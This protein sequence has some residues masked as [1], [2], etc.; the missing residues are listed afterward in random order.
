M[1]LSID[2]K[3]LDLLLEKKRDYIGRKTSIVGLVEAILLVISAYTESYDN[4]LIP[5]LAIKFGILVLAVIQV[6][7]FVSELRKPKYSKE[8]LLR[9]IENLDMARRSSS[10]IAI[11]NSK[12]HLQYLLYKDAGWGFPLFPNYA[13]VSENETNIIR[14]LSDQLDINP[15]QIRLEFKTEGHEIKYS[16]ESKEEREYYYRFYEA[17]IDSFK[18]ED[19]E[20]FQSEG[21]TFIWM[22]IDEMLQDPVINK[23][24]HYVVGMVRDNT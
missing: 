23:N 15:D 6:I 20:E 21:R 9:D 24:N 16:T 5:S 10:I 7:F 2:P 19:E 14:K 4:F 13:T 3:E 8:D 22:T 12:H 11:H 1:K 17:N 18:N